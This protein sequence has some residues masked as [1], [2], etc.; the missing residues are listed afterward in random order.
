MDPV[1]PLAVEGDGMLLAEA[2]IDAIDTLVAVSGP[3]ADTPLLSI[4]LRHLGGALA[5]E[6]PGGGAQPSI[7]STYLMYAAGVATTPDLGETVRSNARAVN[8]ALGAWRVDPAAAETSIGA[9][10]VRD[11]PV[12]RNPNT[13]A[14][15]RV[16]RGGIPGAD[17]GGWYPTRG[18]LRTGTAFRVRAVGAPHD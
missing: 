15:F 1:E 2:P 4:E 5:R 14:L 10:P 9:G 13:V 16:L 6:A 18:S 8:E 7:A 11:V 12:S 3:D 17:D